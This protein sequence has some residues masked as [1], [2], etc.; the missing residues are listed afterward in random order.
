MGLPLRQDIKWKCDTCRKDFNF[1][2][3]YFPD[4]NDFECYCPNCIAVYNSTEKSN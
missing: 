3:M 1:E 2:V 4:P